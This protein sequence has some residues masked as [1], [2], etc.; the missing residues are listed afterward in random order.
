M[1]K[2][3]VVHSLES[4]TQNPTMIGFP[5]KKELD[6]SLS[7][8]KSGKA[9]PASPRVSEMKSGDRIVYYCKGDSVVKGIYEI[10]QSH[11]AK[12]TQWPDSP[13]Q[14]E[15]K[16]IIELEEPY[17]F[18]LLVSSLELFE[19][20]PDRRKW[21]GVLQ[22][23]YNT[24]RQLKDSDYRL[25][26]ESISQANKEIL[27]DEQK[28]KEE[29]P[30]YRQHLL[31]QYK[32][33]E[34][35]LKHGYRVHVAINDK[36]RIKEN[37]PGI[38]DEIPQFHAEQIIRGARR[39]DVLFFQKDRDILTHAFEVEHTTNIYSGLLRLNDIAESYPS[40]EV[41]F[42]II[43]AESNRE[44]FHDELDRPSF[45]LLKRHGCD[46]YDYREVDEAWKEVKSR[47]PPRF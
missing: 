26:E 24:I 43:S 12:E 39:V 31:L 1:N 2:W 22:G 47:K 45:S 46:F 29:T 32:I 41:K 10:V 34:Y 36:N 4:Y 27:K 20:L 15:I 38:L 9:V 40:E 30:D 7:L 37:L 8:D 16:A 23:T 14:F 21:G 28:A 3:L 42:I 19:N 17:D 35:G 33:A 25:I 13:F 5:A 18:K 11:F 6:G 44:K